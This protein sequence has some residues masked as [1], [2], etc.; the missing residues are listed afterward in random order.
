MYSQLETPPPGRGPK[1]SV[2]GGQIVSGGLLVVVESV[3]SRLRHLIG[4]CVTVCC[5]PA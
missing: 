2:L 3:G 4:K 1:N 5:K